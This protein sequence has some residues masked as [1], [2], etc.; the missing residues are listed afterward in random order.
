[1]TPCLGMGS[2]H[3]FLLDI[4]VWTDRI[5]PFSPFWGRLEVDIGNDGQPGLPLFFLEVNYGVRKEAF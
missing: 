4:T 1:M 3:S 5:C 2:F